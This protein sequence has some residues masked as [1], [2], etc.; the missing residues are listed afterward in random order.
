M[1]DQEILSNVLGAKLWWCWVH[2]PKAQWES[3]WKEKYASS[4][5]TSDLIRMFRNIKGSYIWNKVWE[6]K[7]LVQK[8]SF[9]EIRE[10]DLALF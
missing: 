10:G 8:N 1:D 4:W 3:I 9:W 6:N 2:D 5:K 7:S